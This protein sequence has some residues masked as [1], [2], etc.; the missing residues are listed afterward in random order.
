MKIYYAH[1]RMKYHTIMERYEIALIKHKYPDA[2]IINP[3]GMINQTLPVEEIMEQCF[4]IIDSCDM[5]VFSSVSGAVGLGVYKEVEY[6]KETKPNSIAYICDNKIWH[7]E[8]F[9]CKIPDYD[10]VLTEE[11]SK[12]MIYAKV[13][14]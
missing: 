9:F 6:F 11:V 2:E 5:L 8:L 12:N 4:E 10:K 7:R 3:N 13:I 1:S 14:V